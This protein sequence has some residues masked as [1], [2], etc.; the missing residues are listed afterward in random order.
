[1]LAGLGLDLPPPVLVLLSRHLR[2]RRRGGEMRRSGKREGIRRK[3]TIKRNNNV[4][5]ENG[6][7]QRQE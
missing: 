2:K 1:M 4:K 3:I 7:K 5:V 6:G